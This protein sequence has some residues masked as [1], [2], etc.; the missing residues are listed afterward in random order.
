MVDLKSE[1]RRDGRQDE[2]S[3]CCTACTFYTIDTCRRMAISAA[4]GVEQRRHWRGDGEAG[5][6]A[7]RSNRP[8]GGHGKF[9]WRI[10]LLL[11]RCFDFEDASAA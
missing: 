4:M 10:L 9:C 6:I 1:D 5:R 7:A 3:Y 2:A 11:R 8:E